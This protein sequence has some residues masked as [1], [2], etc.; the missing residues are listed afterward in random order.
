[1]RSKLL[2]CNKSKAAWVGMVE[3]VEV[4]VEGEAGVIINLY[5]MRASM[6][7]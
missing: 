6:V 2:S 7:F 1:M 5:R 3:E 4:E